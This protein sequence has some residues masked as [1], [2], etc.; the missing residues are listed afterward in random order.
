MAEEGE[1]G[2]ASGQEA[3]QPIMQGFERPSSWFAALNAIADDRFLHCM[4]EFALG[5]GSMVLVNSCGFMGELL[6][7]L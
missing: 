5:G 4:Y 2:G 1:R 7:L 6:S 3:S